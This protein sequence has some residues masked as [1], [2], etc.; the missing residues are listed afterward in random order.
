MGDESEITSSVLNLLKSWNIV[1][2][3][4]CMHSFICRHISRDQDI[5]VKKEFLELLGRFV[6]KNFRFY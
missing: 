6:R 4:S 1:S 3:E 5:I 2:R